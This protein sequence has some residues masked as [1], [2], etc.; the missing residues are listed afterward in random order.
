MSEYIK[1]Y[2]LN[3]VEIKE[4]KYL[5]DEPLNLSKDLTFYHNKIIF[6][7][8]L[9]RLQN[10][11]KD[12]LSIPLLA[13]GIRDSYLKE[14]YTEKFLIVL[15]T[16]LEVHKKT[17]QFIE[18]YKDVDFEKGTFHL[19]NNSDYMLLLASDIEGITSGI[20]LIEEILNQTLDNF[21]KQ[22]NFDDFIKIRP[23]KFLNCKKS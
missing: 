6:R 13:T 17:N 12:R 18:P 7:K 22:K 3:D 15:F 10:L 8:E 4:L 20:D 16:T 1:E 2:E 11:F 19:M 21:M 23:F 9:T 14:E 5:D